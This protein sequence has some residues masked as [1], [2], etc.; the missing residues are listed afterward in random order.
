MSKI[1]NLGQILGEMKKRID[2]S[3]ESYEMGCLISSEFTPAPDLDNIWNDVCDYFNVDS[4]EVGLEFLRRCEVNTKIVWIYY[5]VPIG[6]FEQYQREEQ[7]KLIE[8]A[9]RKM[10]RQRTQLQKCS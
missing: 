10:I 1:T 9:F 7:E 6:C 5:L 4:L 8:Q 2:S 3:E